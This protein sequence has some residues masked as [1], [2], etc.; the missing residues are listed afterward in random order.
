M[1][2]SAVGIYNKKPRFRGVMHQYAFFLSVPAAVF[3]LQNNRADF[4]WSIFVYAISLMGLFGIS[5]L[6][7]RV[8]WSTVGQRR[9]RIADRTMI[10][11]FIAGNF[12]PFASIAMEGLLP[13]ILLIFLWGAALMGVVVNIFWLDA[14][15]WIHAILY[16]VVSC[17]CF[18]ALP[19]IWS[20]VGA[21]GTSWTLLGGALHLIGALIY[22]IRTPDPFPDTFGYHEV[23]HSLVTIAIAIHYVVVVQYLF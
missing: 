17:M 8:Q 1:E 10:Y 14:P 3:L 22:A 4:F 12:T 23:F 11:L 15:N 16:A 6:Y 2:G 21:V 19:Q 13:V 20:F 7:H 5:A 9:M 18:F